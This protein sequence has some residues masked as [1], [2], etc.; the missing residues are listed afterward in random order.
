MDI[1]SPRKRNGSR[2]ELDLSML[3]PRGSMWLRLCVAFFLFC[4]TQ[5][6]SIIDREVYGEWTGKQGD[7]LTQTIFLS[8]FVLSA[9]FF[10]AGRRRW[11]LLREGA[12]VWLFLAAFLICSAMWSVSAGA[13]VRAGV[14]YASLIVAAIGVAETLEADEF[15][16]ILA[17][18]CFFSALASL[19][20][21]VSWP[22]TVY[23]GSGDFRGV[24][25]QKNSLGEAMALGALACLHGIWAERRRRILRIFMLLTIVVAT[26][27][28]KSTT[29]LLAVLL[30]IGFGTAIKKAG[31]KA[32]LIVTPVALVG[33]F[34]QDFLIEM[35]GKDP[36]LT[37][38][39]DI[40]TH[41]IPDIWQSPLLGW[42]YAAFWTRENP[43]ANN[44]SIA[45]GWWVPEAHNGV[46]EILLSAGLVGAALYLYILIRTFR[47]SIILLRTRK[48]AWGLTCFVNCAGVVLIGVSEEVLIYGSAVT[49]VFIVTALFCER[50]VRELRSPVRY[51]PASAALHL[52]TQVQ[53]F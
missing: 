52:H 31:M 18:V 46:L 49:V 8:Q 27:L 1:C 53:T 9:V 45:L 36:T 14:Q 24:Y 21:L 42:G 19:V 30:F 5:A 11:R 22:A 6:V 47:L 4:Q 3:A 20:L 23:S 39:T 50:Y 48:F 40:W 25:S 37:G 16:N 28:S 15:M 7:K 41:V 51:S 43:A 34:G 2:M 35:L 32:L 10:Y 12:L 33:F 13:T 26:V 38:R 29:S 44:I 17:Q